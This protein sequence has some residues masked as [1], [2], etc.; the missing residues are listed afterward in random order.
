MRFAVRVCTT[1]AD[2]M[3]IMSVGSLVFRSTSLL[4]QSRPRWV[5]LAQADT[6]GVEETTSFGQAFM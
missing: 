6:S 5:E 2:P 3:I 4:I 1:V